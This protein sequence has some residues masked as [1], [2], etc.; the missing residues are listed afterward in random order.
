MSRSGS[1]LGAG[2]GDGGGAGEGASGFGFG[3]FTESAGAEETGD[4]SASPKRSDVRDMP[5]WNAQPVPLPPGPCPVYEVT[6]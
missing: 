2:R 5:P 4:I 6:V 3:A 1:S